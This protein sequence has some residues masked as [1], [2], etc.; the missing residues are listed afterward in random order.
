M[1]Q[2]TPCSSWLKD[3]QDTGDSVCFSC[4]ALL[5][6]WD[7]VFLASSLWP[8]YLMVPLGRI[9]SLYL[10]KIPFLTC[11]CGLAQVTFWHHRT[12][13]VCLLETFRRTELRIPTP[14]GH[15]HRTI[16][17]RRKKMF[18]PGVSFHSLGSWTME[19]LPH[20]KPRD[21]DIQGLWDRNNNASVTPVLWQLGQKDG[22]FQASLWYKVR[23]VF[24]KK[25]I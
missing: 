11:S 3:F 23:P 9:I 24:C 4:F 16:Q 2:W 19:A 21:S 17:V 20:C 5:C 15:R 18:H 14:L 6:F 22:K 1:G 8:S 13:C 10:Q 7:R 12:D 25:L